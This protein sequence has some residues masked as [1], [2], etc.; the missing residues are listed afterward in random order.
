MPTYRQRIVC[1][2][3]RPIAVG[4]V[5]EDRFHDLLQLVRGHGLGD[6][7]GHRGHPERANATRLLRNLHQLDRRG[8]V[9]PRRHAVPQLVQ[10]AFQV[11]LELC[12]RLLVHARRTLVGLHLPI[13]LPDGVFGNHKRLRLVHGLL[14]PLSG[15]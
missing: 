13:G 2:A 5:V 9:A 11:L 6:P 12:Q 1:A 7:I 15:G 3:P 4:V 8:E 10:V 14:P